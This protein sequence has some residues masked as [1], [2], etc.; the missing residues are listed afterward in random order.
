MLQDSILNTLIG[1]VSPSAE[2]NMLV[3]QAGC[4]G[5]ASDQTTD[6][7]AKSADLVSNWNPS[8]YYTPDNM[9][10]ITA[11]VQACISMA[12]TALTN[13][14]A[15]VN[16][17]QVS[18][19]SDLLNS[20]QSRLNNVASQT[21]NYITASKSARAVAGQVVA[22]PALKDWVVECLNASSQAIQ[23]SYLVECEVPSWVNVLGQV[24]GAADTL[25]Q[26]ASAIVGVVASA[27]VS[28]IHAAEAAFDLAAFLAEWG[29]T[30]LLVGI[31]AAIGGSIAFAIHKRNKRRKAA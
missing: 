7:D 16:A 12:Y 24:I 26:V 21:I 5:A 6:I 25:Y 17:S 19:A 22:A 2:F 8:G 4:P 1:A 15:D 29:P 3:Q 31:V 28:V 23:Y 30:L 10:T 11:A 20:A 18:D 27:A 14:L 9:D 13:A